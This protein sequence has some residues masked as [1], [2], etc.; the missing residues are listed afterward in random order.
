MIFNRVNK[1]ESVAKHIV[2]ALHQTIL[3]GQIRPGDKLPGQRELAV[4]FGASLTSVREAISILAATGLISVTPGRGTIVRGASEAEPSF[5]GWLG[6][7]HNDEELKDFLEVRELLET[8]IVRKIARESK[9]KDFGAIVDALNRLRRKQKSPKTYLADDL[10]FHRLLA[11]YSGNKILEKLLLAIQ[12]PMRS[13]IAHSIDRAMEKVGS[14]EPSWVLHRNLVEALIA[15]KPDAA[16][17]AVRLMVHRARVYRGLSSDM[18]SEPDDAP[19]SKRK[20]RKPRRP[21]RSI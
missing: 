14:L 12:I 10:A 1:R 18:P 11:S 6:I 9:T 13:Q 15:G 20:P 21:V 3:S 5:D 8:H 7:A 4:Q 17:E 2:D 16:E 19:A